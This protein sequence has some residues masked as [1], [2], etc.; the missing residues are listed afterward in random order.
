MMLLTYK[1]VPFFGPPCIYIVDIYHECQ[2]WSCNPKG[3]SRD[4]RSLR[5]DISVSMRDRCMV[6]I[7][8]RNR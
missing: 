7:S 5:L 1:D 8:P 4:L 2:P 6:K 3:E